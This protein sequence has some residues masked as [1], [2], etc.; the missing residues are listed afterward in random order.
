MHDGPKRSLVYA[1]PAPPRTD[2]KDDTFMSSLTKTSRI[3]RSPS[4]WLLLVSL[5]LNLFFIGIAGST[6]ARHWLA[7]P[8]DRSDAA[9]FE[10]IAATLPAT[11]ADR[12]RAQFAAQ[13][14]AIEA[15]RQAIGQK[16]E[17]IRTALRA[18]PFDADAL[19]AAM[20]ESRAARETFYQV[21]QGVISTAASDMSPA[22]RS[23][24]ADWRSS[25]SR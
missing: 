17:R 4:R 12:L 3:S 9:R 6:L 2:P 15:G 19:R 22:G 14:T 13:R 10:R 5:A 16:Q 24:L 11:D 20:A 18:E 1:R 7:K 21:L 25:R 23:K 8:V